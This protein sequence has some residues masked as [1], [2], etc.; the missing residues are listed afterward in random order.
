MKEVAINLYFLW[1]LL[2]STVKRCYNS[3]D[4]PMSGTLCLSS[5]LISIKIAT[6]KLII[7]N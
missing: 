7:V 4:I 1:E 5:Y 3:L 6:H 2:L